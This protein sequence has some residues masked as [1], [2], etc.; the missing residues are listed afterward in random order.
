MR[1]P[2]FIFYLATLSFLVNSEGKCTQYYCIYLKIGKA[3]N[4]NVNASR[5]VF[6]EMTFGTSFKVKR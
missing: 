3:Y 4:K 5:N 6:I 1:E 2:L